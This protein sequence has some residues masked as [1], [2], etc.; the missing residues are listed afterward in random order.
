M[1]K[2][3]I[4]KDWR[5]GHTINYIWKKYKVAEDKRRKRMS[6]NKITN[7]EAEAYVTAIIFEYQTALLK[8]E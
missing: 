1:S 4:I 7:K 8:G 5:I 2:E 3:E 6:E